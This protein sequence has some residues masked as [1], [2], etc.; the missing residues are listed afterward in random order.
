MFKKKKFWS[1]IELTI[2][3]TVLSILCAILAPVID[4]Y[5]RNAKVIRCREDV[6]AIGCSIA[7]FIEDTANSYFLRDGSH[8]PAGGAGRGDSDFTPGSAPD[9]DVGNRVN[10]LV[11][12]GDVP[13]VGADGDN[14]WAEPV[15]YGHRDFIEYHIV[16]NNPGSSTGNAYR[17]P[18]D[19]INGAA[20]QD[21]MFARYESGGFN[22]EFAWRGPYMTAPIDPDP[23]GNRYAINSIYLDPCANSSNDDVAEQGHGGWEY[24]CVVLS[25][26]PDEEIDTLF[27]VDG[28]T[29]GDDDIIYTVSGNSRP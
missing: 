1:L 14:D 28:L 8:F 26:G 13:E 17:T 27:A 25:A 4:R 22:S 15:D 9:Q 2:I 19:L 7:M 5:V 29:P 21:P 11:S 16:S 18:T 12:D 20:D 23:W 10:L 3:L 6:Q 24:D